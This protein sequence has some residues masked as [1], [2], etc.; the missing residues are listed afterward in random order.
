MHDLQDDYEG[1]D[2]NT[3]RIVGVKDVIEV[4]ADDELLYA[5]RQNRNEYVPFIKNRERQPCSTISFSLRRINDTSYKLESAW[6]GEYDSPPFPEESSAIP[7]SLPFWS[8]HAFVWGSQG[9]Q[10]DS[11]TDQRPW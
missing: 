10:E 11:I 2:I 1:F 9:V 8:T 3:K 5:K 4:N 6:I 7:E